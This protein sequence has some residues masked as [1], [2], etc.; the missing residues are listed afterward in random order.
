MERLSLK[1]AAE[2]SFPEGVPSALL[3]LEIRQAIIQI[4]SSGFHERGG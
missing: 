1:R 3:Q 4:D 2:D